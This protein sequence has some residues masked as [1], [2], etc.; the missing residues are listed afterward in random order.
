MEPGEP[1]TKISNDPINANKKA[2]MLD[3]RL[4]GNRR[5]AYTCGHPFKYSRPASDQPRGRPHT[6]STFEFPKCDTRQAV[7]V[8]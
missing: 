7:R 4:T 3:F 5:A 6:A 1:R 8:S 2:K